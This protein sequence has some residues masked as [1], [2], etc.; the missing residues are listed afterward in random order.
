MT[1]R[2]LVARVA[3]TWVVS[4]VTAAAQNNAA[5]T[6]TLIEALQ[7]KAGSVVAEV[8]AG[9]GELTI[10]IAKHVGPTG[11]VFTSELGT[12]RVA[13]LQSAVKQA[14]AQNVQV[15]EGKDN[16]ANLA[17]GCCDA[18]FMRNVYHHF[19][20]P[21]AMLAS[22]LRALKPGGRVAV[23]DFVPGK[24]V[25]TAPPGKR[26]EDGSHGVTAETVEA[27]LKAAGFELVSS[28]PGGERWFVVVAA[29]P[30]A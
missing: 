3:L 7:L 2:A 10:A 19:G 22:F 12:E 18:M 21:P 11:R 23:I 15:I 26:G 28:K 25:P 16:E 30:K 14:G 5:D 20:A 17:D 9:D 13:K 1:K 24:N 6:A 8:G 27:E 4:V 29:K